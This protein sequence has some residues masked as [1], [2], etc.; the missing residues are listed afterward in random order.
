MTE[1]KTA[2]EKQKKPDSVEAQAQAGERIFKG[3]ST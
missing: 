2:T 3:V 1:S